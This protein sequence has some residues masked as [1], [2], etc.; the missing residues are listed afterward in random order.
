[1]ERT[2]SKDWLYKELRGNG[3]RLIILDCRSSNE[4]GEYH[5]RQAV[6]FSIPTI[7]LRRLAAGKIDLISTIKS[8][9]LKE[10]I[11]GAYK[12]N[13]FV[14]Y[15]E[16][17]ERSEVISTLSKRLSQ[18]GCDVVYLEDGFAQ[19]RACYPEWCDSLDDPLTATDP[20][21]PLMGLR[22]LRISNYG[23]TNCVKGKEKCTCEIPCNPSGYIEDDT[24]VE[25][26]P[27]LFL[28]NAVNSEDLETLTKHNIKYVLNVTPNL[29]NVFEASGD[30]KYMK[31]PITDHWSQDLTAHFPKTI[32]FIDEA[33]NQEKGVLV[34]C[35]AGVSRSVTVTLA[36]LMA[37]HCLS[38]NDAFIWVRNRKPNIAPN[39]HFMEELARFEQDLMAK[40][41]GREGRSGSSAWT[42]PTEGPLSTTFLSPLGIGQ[43]PD[44]GIEFDRWTP[45]TGE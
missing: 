34:H 12:D 23:P 40:G 9:E 20:E 31:I 35:V 2:V 5:I 13:I 19:F 27:H 21:L 44:S 28:G 45:N 18:D 7:M 17:S 6:N 3:S 26:L 32:E 11:A 22:S 4:Y 30:I 43:S 10:K 36:Y 39:F 16:N 33:R 24:L 41:D 14:L 8:R 25:I 37:R 15:D 42:R 29:P 38:M 1:M